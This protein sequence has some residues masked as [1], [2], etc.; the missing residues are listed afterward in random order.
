MLGK[1]L[2]RESIIGE[3][4]TILWKNIHPCLSML[5]SIGEV[6]QGGREGVFLCQTNETIGDQ[7]KMSSIEN[8][9]HS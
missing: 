6:D 8:F 4:F 3:K 9:K 5:Q 7:G 2:V 1:S